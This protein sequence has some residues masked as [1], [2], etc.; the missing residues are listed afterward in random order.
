MECQVK[1]EKRE[2]NTILVINR[3]CFLE[4]EKRQL[5]RCIVTKSCNRSQQCD[6]KLNPEKVIGIVSS[7]GKVVMT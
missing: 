3:W 7:W 1:W 4:R 2:G 6:M 5:V